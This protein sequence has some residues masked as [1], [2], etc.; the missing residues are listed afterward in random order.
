MYKLTI[1]LL[2]VA[3]VQ[4]IRLAVDNILKW[5]W[6]KQRNIELKEKNNNKI[7]GEGRPQLKNNWPK[8]TAWSAYSRGKPLWWWDVNM[9]LN[10]LNTFAIKRRHHPILFLLVL[11]LNFPLNSSSL[12]FSSNRTVGL[13]FLL[14]HLKRAFYFILNTPSSSNFPHSLFIFFFSSC[15]TSFV[16]RF[17]FLFFFFFRETPHDTAMRDVTLWLFQFLRVITDDP[18]GFVSFLSDRQILSLLYS[19]LF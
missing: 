1:V 15:F 18:R 6:T 7:N 3:Q 2:F 12:L 19:P 16:L 14:Y 10:S 4:N 8:F 9:L 11:P 17:S 5:K 13:T